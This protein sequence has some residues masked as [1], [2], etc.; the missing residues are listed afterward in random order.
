MC[1]ICL[2]H[3]CHPRC[4]NY[5]PPKAK[6][7]CNVCEEGI[8]VGDK[9]IVNDDGEYAHWDCIDYG[10]DLVEFLG[11]EINTMEDDEW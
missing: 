10:R 9:Y 8:Y 3:P 11:Y 1:S 4:P 7:Y 5:D 6:H 2:Q